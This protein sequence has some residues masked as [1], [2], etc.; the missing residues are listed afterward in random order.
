[1]SD[2]KYE[3]KMRL[4]FNQYSSRTAYKRLKEGINTNN[5]HEIYAATGELLLWIMTT[6]EWHL[7][8]G[9]EDYIDRRNKN[10]NGMLLNGMRHAY[11]M[12]K[13]NMGFFQIHQKEGGLKFPVRFP[14]NF[15]ITVRWVVAGEVLNGTYPNQKQNY[16]KHLEGKE[17]IQTFSQV[18]TFLNVENQKFH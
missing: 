14:V 7:E 4:K 13:H 18:L 1:M 8:H 10:K 5:D 9:M 6:D 12:M 17:V 15:K 3:H 16:I 11:N 2:L